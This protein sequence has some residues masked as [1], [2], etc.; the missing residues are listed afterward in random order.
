MLRVNMAI[1]GSLNTVLHIPAI[2][3]ELGIKIDMD[4]FDAMSREI[5]HL[6]NIEP[7]GPHFLSDL[8]EA[9]GIP[10][11]MKR[12]EG[13]LNLDALTVTGRKIRDNI[14][15]AE[16]FNEE[17][18]RPL[19]SPVHEYGGVA[20]LRGSLAPG[21]AVIKQVAVDESLWKFEGPARAFDCE[22]DATQALLSQQIQAG[23]V[24]VIRY[25]GPKGG[26][27]MREMAHFRAMLKFAGLGDK[28][29][30]IT[31]G[32]YSGYSEGSSIG[33]LSPEAAEGGPIAL[34]RDGDI[35]SIDI[36]A[37]TLHVK[38]SESEL[39]ERREQW[40]RPPARVTK[41]YLARYSAAAMSAA[42]G[43]IL[44]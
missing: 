6:C 14:E 17:V 2:A 34:V 37:R 13:K 18:I 39:D 33:Y 26:P 41:G 28:V 20:V 21:G 19:E 40:K 8:E 9:G 38:L 27:G 29:Y 36:E 16:I 35:I 4:M 24:V 11:V 42:E 7:S 22:E 1:G 5:P 12:L 25:E 30:L 10:G 23:D 15:Q 31:D 44:P 3:H 43:A 32:R